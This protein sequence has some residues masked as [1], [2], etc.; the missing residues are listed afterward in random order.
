[1]KAKHTICGQYWQISIFKDR[2]ELKCYVCPCCEG[3][4]NDNKKAGE[5]RNPDYSH[6]DY[7][8]DYRVGIEKFAVNSDLPEIEIGGTR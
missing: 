5:N 3:G 1:M 2:R 8:R 7:I 6:W 4:Q